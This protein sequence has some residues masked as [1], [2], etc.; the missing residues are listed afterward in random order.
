MKIL[1]KKAAY[2]FLM[3]WLISLISFAAVKSAPNNFLAAGELNPN[4]T[5]ESITRLKEV[6]G[7]DKPLSAQYVDWVKNIA[8]LEFGISFSSGI[9]VK[10]EILSR[11]NITLGINISS[12]VIIFA[13]GLFIGI[14]SAFLTPKKQDLAAT[15]LLASFAMPS[16]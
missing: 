11:I 2:I 7:L 15:A 12:M 5:E 1:L 4:I 13:A 9:T 8:S 6:Y 14:W 3:F 16:S 10:E